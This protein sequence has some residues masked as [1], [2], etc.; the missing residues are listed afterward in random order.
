MSQTKRRWWGDYR[1]T[2][3]ASID[4]ETTIAVLPIAAIEQH[5]PHLP[6][7]TDTT[8]MQG[9]L[10]TVISRLPGDLDI[11]I[12][13]VQSVGKSNEHLYAPG[14]L[15]L[16]APVLIE[17]WTELGAS[18][19]RAGVKK[20]VFINSHGGNEEI[21]GIVTRE[22]RVRFSMLAV[23]TSWQRFGRPAGM[24]TELEDRHGIHGGDVE[25][26]LMLHFRPDLVDMAKA[27]NFVS[28]VARAE[29]EFGLLRHTGTHAFAWIATDL[30]PNGVVGDASIATAEK[31]RLTAEHQTDG[32]VRLLQD[33]RAASLTGYLS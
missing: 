28:S 22:L 20:I 14:T 19:A 23:K 15:T 32:F 5:G 17:A 26:S 16:P 4:P 7:S 6:V 31:G 30:N 10:E 25:T 12:L 1:T 9:M 2:E 21:M 3:Y 24:Y 33:V 27:Q 13:P 18:V 8:I 11:R 29:N